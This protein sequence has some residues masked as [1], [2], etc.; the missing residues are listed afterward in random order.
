[1]HNT[2]NTSD[3][4]PNIANVRLLFPAWFIACYNS[5][6]THDRNKRGRVGDA[7]LLDIWLMYVKQRGRCT[8]TLV[9]MTW[10]DD[11]QLKPYC[12]SIDRF[13]NSKPHDRDNIQLVIRCYNTSKAGRNDGDVPVNVLVQFRDA[14]R[15]RPLDTY[16]LQG[17][18]TS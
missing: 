13:D 9:P 6:R 4:T 18:P 10:G 7:T 15:I 17:S 1:M 11:P 2:V 8:Q 5:I 16:L 3:V 14:Y 12:V